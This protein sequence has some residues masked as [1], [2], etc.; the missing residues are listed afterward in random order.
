MNFHADVGSLN[1]YIEQRSSQADTPNPQTLLWTVSRSQANF[2]YRARVSVEYQTDF[3]L[4][5]VGRVMRTMVMQKQRKS[6]DIILYFSCR[7]KVYSR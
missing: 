6:L 7:W 5:L 3:R 1:V 2:W 4:I